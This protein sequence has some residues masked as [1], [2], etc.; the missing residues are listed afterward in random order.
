MKCESATEIDITRWCKRLTPGIFHFVCKINWRIYSTS[1]I[2]RC[3]EFKAGNKE[4]QWERR[5]GNSNS[6]TITVHRFV[7]ILQHSSLLIETVILKMYSQVSV[8]LETWKW[9]S[10]KDFRFVAWPKWKYIYREMKEQEES[11]VRWTWKMNLS[12]YFT[13]MY[14]SNAMAVRPHV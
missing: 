4:T 1:D 3:V 5:K 7:H 13:K 10:E 2:L 8:F 11:L 12:N 14:K 6:L 9:S